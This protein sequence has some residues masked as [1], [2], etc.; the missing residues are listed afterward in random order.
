MVALFELFLKFSLE[1]LFLRS[2]LKG[3]RMGENFKKASAWDCT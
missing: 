3:L 2:K 1:E